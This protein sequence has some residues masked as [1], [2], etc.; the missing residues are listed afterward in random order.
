MVNSLFFIIN[1]RNVHKVSLA[2]HVASIDFNDLQAE[3]YY[4]PY[5]AYAQSKLA[6]VLTAYKKKKKHYR[7]PL[8]LVVS[9]EG[10]YIGTS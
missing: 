7:D 8:V 1:W 3:K 9:S 2:K 10:V 4:S 5:R 6:T